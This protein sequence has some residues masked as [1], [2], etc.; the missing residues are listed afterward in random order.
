MRGGTQTVGAQSQI[1]LIN[2]DEMNLTR[3]P[4]NFLLALPFLL[5]PSTALV[6]ILSAKWLGK[7]LGYVLGF[8]FYWIVWCLFVP[9]SILK[10]EGIGTLFKEENRLFQKSNWLP[11]VLLVVIVMVT[12]VIYHPTELV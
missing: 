2:M 12:V 5:V 9:L 8:V 11:A 3:S 4:K 7:E 6:F 1:D 10:R